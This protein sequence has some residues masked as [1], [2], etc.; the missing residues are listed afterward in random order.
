MFVGLRLI[1]FKKLS[2]KAL[3]SVL[4]MIVTKLFQNVSF[5]SYLLSYY[6]LCDM[7]VTRNKE[8]KGD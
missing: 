6:S 7:I 3:N 5:F 8:K 2:R 4:F 1:Y